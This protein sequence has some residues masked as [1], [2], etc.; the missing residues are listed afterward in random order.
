MAASEIYGLQVEKYCIIMIRQSYMMIIIET[1]CM[2]LRWH[3]F[4][5]M[6]YLPSQLEV[7]QTQSSVE[8]RHPS[9]PVALDKAD[10]FKLEQ[11]Q[12][13]QNEYF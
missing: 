7:S 1:P 13:R 6:I 10:P 11:W 2:L 3:G 8:V 9:D 4:V 12:Q 5:L